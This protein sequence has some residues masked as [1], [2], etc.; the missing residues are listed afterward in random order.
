MLIINEVEFGDCHTFCGAEWQLKDLNILFLLDKFNMENE[1]T[2]K[3]K[4]KKN[5]KK[6]YQVLFI[7]SSSVSFIHD[8]YEI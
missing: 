6:T 4:C 3:K 2:F 1:V 7:S 8:L 5:I